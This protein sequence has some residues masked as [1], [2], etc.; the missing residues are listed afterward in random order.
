MDTIIAKDINVDK[1]QITFYRTEYDALKKLVELF[2]PKYQ[3]ILA[4]YPC[5]NYLFMLSKEK[6]VNL[7]YY[8]FAINN[9]N[10]QPDFKI[11]KSYIN[12]KTKMIYLSSPNTVTGQSI[13]EE[14]FDEFMKTVP[15][16]IPIIID[17]SYLEF[18][19]NKKA[20]DPLKYI[21][22]NVIVM[23][24]MNN[25]YGFENLELSYIISDIEIATMLQKSQIIDM[26]LNK[27]NEEIA[28]TAYKDRNYNKY[29]KETMY[30]ERQRLYKIFKE[31]NI[32]Y[33]PS[34]VN[35]ILIKANK[36]RGEIIEE[37]EKEKIIFY[38]SNDVHFTHWTLPIST[39]KINNKVL[40]VLT[41]EI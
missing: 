4:V 10:I 32:Q 21:D 36:T 16:N 7:K 31:N 18:S 5:W 20:V 14:D 41:D 23:R 40:Q 35:F 9:K 24:T 3:D 19:F 39:K 15:D 11:L 12:Q 37:L 2:V 6:K 17:Q 38:A 13:N 1:N 22:K 29:V 33:Y 28:L 30:K 25:F 27:F 34:E 26:P 8:T